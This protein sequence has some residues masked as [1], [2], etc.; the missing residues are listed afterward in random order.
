[1]ARCGELAEQGLVAGGDL[2]QQQSQ[3]PEA[4]FLVLDQI[5]LF[6]G[7]E[8]RE[9]RG[10]GGTKDECAVEAKAGGIERREGARREE[11]KEPAD[12]NVASTCG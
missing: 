4:R 3:I 9:G 12:I 2:S 8:E 10:R 11:R 6:K 7:R 1:M 5:A